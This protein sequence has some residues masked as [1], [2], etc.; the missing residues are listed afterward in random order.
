MS[1]SSKLS[2]SKP[3]KGEQI[4]S[5]YGS[6]DVITANS[7]ILETV[8]IAGVYEDGVFLNVSIKDSDISNTVIGAEGASAAYFTYL[9]VR[10]DVLFQDGDN[11]MRWDSN[12]G[13]LSL[14]DDLVVEGCSYLGNIEICDNTIRAVN[15]NGDINIV[16]DNTGT[17]YVRGAFYNTTTSGNFYS[18]VKNGGATI[19]VRDNIVLYSSS[20]TANVTTFDNQTY[21]AVNGDIT[22]GTES[23]TSK[24]IS[25]ILNT[26]GSVL[27][28]TNT[29]HGLKGGDLIT[30]TGANSLN[31]TYTVGS[32]IS[33]TSFLLGSV[34][35]VI[36]STITSGSFLKTL[37]NK[38]V[39]D[40]ANMITIPS[41]TELV[42]G[43]TCNNIV[44]NTSSLMISSCNDVV[45]NVGT[46]SSIKIPETTE[47]QFGTSGNN[48]INFLGN[49]EG[50]LNVFGESQVKINGPMM[51]ISTTNTRFY[52]PIL[53]LGDYT[54]NGSES[55]DRGIEYR[56]FDSIS[57]SMKLGWFGYK[58]S[59]NKFTFMVDAI[60]T[61]ELITGTLGNFDMGALSTMQ[62]DISSGGNLNM[63]C[64]NIIGVNTISGCGGVINI[65]AGTRVSLMTG[66]VLL[67]NNVPLSFGTNG[68][69]ILENTVSSLVISSR[70]INLSASSMIL[71]INS[72]ISF[73]GNSVGL[74]RI[75]GNT[76]GE[77]LINA[78]SNIYLTPS[79]GS[80]IVP[81]DINVQ[82]GGVSQVI[83]GNTG[84]IVL[85]TGNSGS[86]LNMVSNGRVNV[87]SSFGNVELNANSGDI[88]LYTSVGST[89]I[90][91]NK[92]LVFSN[93]GTSNS[94]L[95]S[96]GN[97]VIN[98]SGG[99]S[100]INLRNAKDI[101]LLASSAVNIPVGV[102]LTFSD[103][104]RYI[105]ADTSG[106]L[107]MNSNSV[108]ISNTGGRLIINNE[109]TYITS[110]NFNVSGNV[111]NFDS[112]NVRVRDP[113][114][115]LANY[116]ILADD[117]K[118]RGVEYKY[119]DVTSGSMKLGWFGWKDSSNRFT[120]YSDAINTGEVITGTLG[121]ME[122]GG[123]IISNNLSFTNAG[124]I[125]MNCGTI[126]NVRTLIGC[127]GILN[128][129]GTNSVNVTS[130][131]IMLNAGT[132]VELP[133]NIPIAFGGTTVSISGDTNGNM[134][135]LASNNLIIDANVQINGTTMNVYS[136]VTNIQDPIVSLGGV[137]GPIV[138][139]NKDRG[140][141]FKWGNNVS[142]RTGF[143]GYKNDLGRFVYIQDG[144]N[145]NE[146]FSGSYGSVQ[147]GDGYFSNL[148]LANGTISNVKTITGN[149]IN[150]S[151]GNIII[152]F[153]SRIGFGSTS[154]S[155]SGDTG[156]NIRITS[157]SGGISLLT[158][159]GGS[160]FIN[161][162]KNTSLNVGG[163]TIIEGTSGNIQIINTSGNIDLQPKD[164]IT[165]PVNK[166]L[167]FGTINNSI[168]SD[169]Q[170]LILNG[171]NGISMNS[172]SVTISGSVNITGTLSTSN[173][174]FD[175]N[176]F[177]LP[178][179]TFQ[180]MLIMGINSYVGS[181]NGNI[182]ITT[183]GVN[184]LV[185]G[186]KVILSNTNSTPVVDGEYTVVEIIDGS[187]FLISKVGGISVSGS[188]GNVKSNLKVNPGKDVGIGVN[189]W[190]DLVGNNI[191]TGSVN[192]HTGFF[193]WKNTLN[194]WMF[195]SDAVIEDDVVLSGTLGSIEVSK[196][197]TS[198]MS[199]FVLDGG[200]S[201]GSNRVSGSD[202]RINGGSIDTTP[203]GATM[204]QTGRFTSLSNT[205]LALF[206]DVTMETSLKFNIDRYD[207]TSSLPVSNPRVDRVLTVFTVTGVNY[208]SSVG[209]M[210]SNPLLVADG[211]YKMLVCGGMGVG[212]QH[213]INFGEDRLICPNPMTG[214]KPTK[215]V[216]KRKGQSC[217]L[218]Y[219]QV[220]GGWIL[221]NSG[222]YVV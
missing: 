126:A 39:L 167:Q 112:T 125:D 70:N 90:L 55:K 95:G 200:I 148:D 42:F 52:D 127:G 37:T 87:N 201:A 72:Y 183:D 115:T 150:I 67:P 46:S 50:S 146:V 98:G 16:P 11:F 5:N 62:L 114:I 102:Y 144:I 134:R 101:N 71:P 25:T 220:L 82:L 187:K 211:T 140:V 175:L 207:I 19:N 57:N 185:V 130:S 209:E 107:V 38:I 141:E 3:L 43:P 61:N 184:Y 73:S 210:Q 186:D 120:Y 123:A 198:N 35:T 128:V 176:K 161:I 105:V 131:N 204:P 166:Y 139:D 99:S 48:Y 163:S 88:Y 6:F 190:R 68:S 8:N 155:I 14:S 59:T 118:D 85:L 58:A 124:V 182:R 100:S 34:G 24:N 80:V 94:I 195:Y 60:N 83:Y 213:T 92:F 26:N 81:S 179:G 194:R 13:V 160:G 93:G 9:T 193:G 31:N 159:T 168:L 47:L 74:Q 33:N 189:Y 4:I 208:T 44:G 78:S 202:F 28:T 69:N 32:I 45:F 86:S 20:G 136:T 143:F 29:F 156:G 217:S 135:I 158:N 196:V 91:E 113:I 116:D 66:Q 1:G 157:L 170:N 23:L 21:R 27:V 142:T 191:V 7:I 151:S 177:I 162:N 171:Y 192:Y 132:K 89:R 206:R 2:F 199:G 121:Q 149:D 40:T 30:I 63:N 172:S 215:L 96:S 109:N 15:T 145:N 122:M 18:E 54:L 181:T 137:S 49:T 110:S 76:S 221:L 180:Q 36:S 133:Y 214:T 64:G 203:I 56:Y 173:T 84:G 117:N 22:I 41:E 103:G 138:N 104:S 165:V 216:F 108:I 75:S 212:C 17:V 12:T 53:T 153:N 97:L 222:A 174:D 10:N 164:S 79:G 152:P 169:G 119:F 188:M 106:N 147:F 65:S 154:S 77:L 197:N 111:I 51:Q 178:L 205:T 218:V 219:D 129:I